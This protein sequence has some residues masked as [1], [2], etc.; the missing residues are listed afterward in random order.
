MDKCNVCLCEFKDFELQN[1]R[2]CCSVKLCNACYI[3]T[4]CCPQCR[5]SGMSNGCIEQKMFKVNIISNGYYETVVSFGTYI[6]KTRF[7]D[8]G[9]IFY[10]KFCVDDDDEIPYNRGNEPNHIEYIWKNDKIEATVHSWM[11]DNEGCLHREDGPALIEY[12]DDGKVKREVY[13]IDGDYLDDDKE[14]YEVLY[15]RSGKI[16]YQ[17]FIGRRFNFYESGRPMCK[18][19]REFFKATYEFYGDDESHS[20]IFKFTESDDD[21][22][23]L[24]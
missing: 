21:S 17:K 5:A 1:P 3:K 18:V 10:T 6:Q 20:V 22:I 2:F 4:G 14:P 7:G 23:C 15:Y 16:E 11:R 13:Y 9:K 8:G 19:I 24:I 12:Y